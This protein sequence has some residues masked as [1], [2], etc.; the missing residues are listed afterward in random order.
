MIVAKSLAPLQGFLLIKAAYLHLP[1]N[2]CV[3]F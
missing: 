2:D 3:Y 1:F